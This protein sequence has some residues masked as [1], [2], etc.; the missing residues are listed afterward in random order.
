MATIPTILGWS[1]RL[2]ASQDDGE[3]F[4][5][6]VQ[7]SAVGYD[8]AGGGRV[9][10]FGDGDEALDAQSTNTLSIPWFNFHRGDTMGL[11]ADAARRFHSPRVAKPASTAQ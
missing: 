10:L 6:S 2:R 9:R 5:P 7:A 8:P 4:T 3:T 11:T 1:L